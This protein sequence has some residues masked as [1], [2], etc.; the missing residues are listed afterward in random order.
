[1]EPASNDRAEAKSGQA[2]HIR[3][4]KEELRPPRTPAEWARYHDIRRHVLFELRGRG[5]AYDA[6]HPDEHHPHHHPLVL[7]IDD[8]AVGV[9]R[10]DVEDR[11]ALYR[12]VAIRSDRQRRD[13]GRRLLRLAEQFARDLG[14]DRV[15]SNVDRD[16]VRFYERC[17]FH[18]LD[19]SGDSG[20]VIPMGK[21][22]S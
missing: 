19:A 18:R 8:D 5:A 16:A 13:Y 6:D 14:C 15:V 2:S 21:A 20:H 1:M 9:I 11:V 22:I 10:V 4:M 3:A 17:G 12:R 7:W